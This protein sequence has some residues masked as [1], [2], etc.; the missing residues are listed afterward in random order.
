MATSW[1]RQATAHRWTPGA[2]SAKTPWASL[3]ERREGGVFHRHATMGAPGFTSADRVGDLIM[4]H[5]N[6]TG[7]VVRPDQNIL[8]TSV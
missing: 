4:P 3:A 2:T 6:T 5:E 1:G 7:G 8:T